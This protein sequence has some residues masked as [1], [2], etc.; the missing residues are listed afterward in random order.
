MEVTGSAP[1]NRDQNVAD[2]FRRHMGHVSRHSAAF[3]A[4]TMF[5]SAAGYFFKVYLARVLGAEALGLYALGMTI[6]GFLGTFNAL[7]LSQSA[8]RFVSAYTATGRLEQLRGF[9]WR[10][11]G[12]LVIS[13][14]FLAAV[15][16]WIGPWIA[17]HFY[18][19]PSLQQYL[20]LFV[21]IMILGVLN[22]FCAQILTGFKDVARRTVITSFLVTTLTIVFTL[23][24]VAMGMGLRGYILAQVGSAAL[25][26]VL[27]IASVRKLTPPPARSL[28]LPLP[29]ME[30]Q[31]FTFAAAV[32]GMDF[33]VFLL[34]QADKVL[35]GFYLSPREV[36]IYSIAMALV[37][38][39]PVALQ[40]VNQIFSPTI[41]DLHA[42]GEKQLL[43][44]M[45]QVLTKWILAFTI[46]LAGAMFVF[47]R[48]I[49]LIFGHEFEA[50][51][52]I[53]V[54]GTAG[55]LVNCA[56]GS[57]GYLLLMSD[58][59]RMLFKIQITMT[60]LILLLN[61]VLIPRMGIAGAA[62]AGAIVTV[63][64]NAWSLYVVRSEL[65]LSPYNRSY[66]RMLTPLGAS[67]GLLLLARW[68]AMNLGPAWIVMGTTLVL[69]YAV[70]FACSLAWSLDEDDRT[71]A[72]AVWQRVR[73]FSGVL[74]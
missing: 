43:G 4:G 60:A 67:L 13:N 64:T 52:L 66:L 58:R 74:A 15:V 57:V 21:L 73:A 32:F 68:K 41:A 62:L 9:L 18:H 22:T 51:W 5:T 27:L 10:S 25:A 55:Q 61:A 30:R 11:A 45:F 23:A 63:L 28:A 56:V 42:R 53:L 38:F 24:L 69:A 26:L 50:G 31:V 12:I 29:P 46:P 35:I 16:L 8:V 19:A 48:P 39:V 36:G 49:M 47:S 44:R 33:L 3:F 71:I 65:G 7:G 14:L 1:A 54:I 37:A 59:Q 2:E 72:R 40:S 34:G 20:G 70:F 17:V 6:V